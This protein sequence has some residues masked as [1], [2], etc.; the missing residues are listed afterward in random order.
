MLN[1]G[2]LYILKAL[3]DLIPLQIHDTS[4][5]NSAISKK[6]TGNREVDQYSSFCISKSTNPLEVFISPTLL[7]FYLLLFTHLSELCSI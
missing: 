5:Q 2:K 6:Q 7:P 1:A 3:T 4:K